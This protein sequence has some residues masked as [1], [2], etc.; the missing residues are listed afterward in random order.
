[1]R[2]TSAEACGHRV[3]SGRMAAMLCL[4]LVALS[5]SRLV[6]A[7]MHSSA[8]GCW[9]DYRVARLCNEFRW[10]YSSRDRKI[11]P[12]D[13]VESRFQATSA[14]SILAQVNYGIGIHDF[15]SAIGSTGLLSPSQVPFPMTPCRVEAATNP[16]IGQPPILP[17]QHALRLAY[18]FDDPSVFDRVMR[19]TYGDMS[20]LKRDRN[21]DE[22]RQL[23]WKATSMYR[24]DKKAFGQL[25]RLNPAT[26][27]W[28]L[29]VLAY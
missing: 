16:S 25:I 18:T 15:S 23:H 21:G 20:F 27:A 1:M 26:V 17:M 3:P 19:S 4:L 14:S 7:P 11:G 24:A 29:Q 9:P 13:D 2:S 5:V 22:L 6:G 10:L 12:A 8:S 28:V